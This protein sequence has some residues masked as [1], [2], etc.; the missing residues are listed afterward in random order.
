[1]VGHDGIEAG[2][3]VSVTA[4]PTVLTVSQ[5]SERTGLSVSTVRREISRGHLRAR[6]IGRCVRV[7]DEDLATWLRES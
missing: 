7:L 3:P 2:G 4:L 5:V 6:Y 1:M